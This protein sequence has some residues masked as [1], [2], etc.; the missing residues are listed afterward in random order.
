MDVGNLKDWTS[1]KE[2]GSLVTMNGRC[3]AELKGY[4]GGYKK[5][6]SRIKSRS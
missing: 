2:V 4:V 6:S 1:E 5:S 3:N